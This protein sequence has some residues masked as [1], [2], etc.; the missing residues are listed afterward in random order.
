MKKEEEEERKNTGLKLELVFPLCFLSSPLKGHNRG[1]SMVSLSTL[2][3]RLIE[4]DRLEEDDEKRAEKGTKQ[5]RTLLRETRQ[6]T[7]GAL[8][9]RWRRSQSPADAIL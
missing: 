9:V 8:T 3:W 1:S 5:Q 2:E 6:E 7:K 4:K